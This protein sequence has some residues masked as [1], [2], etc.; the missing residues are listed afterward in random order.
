MMQALYFFTTDKKLQK[1]I[2][3]VAHIELKSGGYIVNK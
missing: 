1:W 2:A 3:P